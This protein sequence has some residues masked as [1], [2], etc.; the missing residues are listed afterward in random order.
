MLGA[1][2]IRYEM[3]ERRRAI[4]L[5]MPVGDLVSNG[6]YMVI[7]SLAWTLKAWWGNALRSHHSFT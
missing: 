7:A 3:A 6:A 5:R 1:R 4:P 2:N